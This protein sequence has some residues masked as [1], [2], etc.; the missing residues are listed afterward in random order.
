MTYTGSSTPEWMSWVLDKVREQGASYVARPYTDGSHIKSPT[1]RNYFRP[2]ISAGKATAAIIVKDTSAERKSKAIIAVYIDS[3]EDIGAKEAY[4]MELSALAASLRATVLADGTLH[5]TGSD[6]KSVLDLIPSR[7]RRLQNVM[8]DHYFLL[9]CLANS[10]YRG[11]TLPYKVPS[12][13]ER[14]K[15]QKNAQGRLDVGWTQECVCGNHF[16]Q[17]LLDRPGVC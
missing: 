15:K 11:A 3:G 7:G 9:Q 16:L 5:A 6:A 14:D 2:E 13:A 8:K 17:G 12:H 10:L 4:T 1:I